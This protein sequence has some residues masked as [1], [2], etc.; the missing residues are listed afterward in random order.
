MKASADSVHRINKK[1]QSERYV[2]FPDEADRNLPLLTSVIDKPGLHKKTKTEAERLKGAI[3]EQVGRSARKSERPQLV[4]EPVAGAGAAPI[5]ENRPPAV[6]EPAPVTNAHTDAAAAAAPIIES[7]PPAVA[8]P[9][10]APAANA[11]AAMPNANL[12]SSREIIE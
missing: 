10:P 6:A 4:S 8:E 11:P 12:N 5:V 7:R 2:V 3:S 1:V 9:A